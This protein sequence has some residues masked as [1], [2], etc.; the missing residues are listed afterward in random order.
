[1]ITGPGLTNILTAI[2]QARADSVPILVV[3]EV[4]IL[5]SLGKGMGHLH[6]LPDQQAMSQSI[7]RASE[8]VEGPDDLAPALD[9][10]YAVFQSGRPGPTHIEI[11]ALLHKCADGIH[12]M[13]PA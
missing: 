5:A 13:N 3:S 11:P 7:A 12:C 9:R 10:A 2:G 8:R 4:N 1:M 6:E